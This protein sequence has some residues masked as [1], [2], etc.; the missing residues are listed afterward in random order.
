[1]SDPLSKQAYATSQ[2]PVI[3]PKF[4]LLVGFIVGISVMSIEMAASRLLTPYF[5]N[6][7]YIWTNIIGVIM[8]ALTIGYAWGGKIA[9][10][11][12][13]ERLLYVIILIAGGYFTLVPWLARTTIS[14]MLSLVTENPLS[15]FY[16]SFLSILPLFVVPFVCLGMVSPYIIR[17][18]SHQ[19]TSIGHIAGRIAAY[20]TFGSI[21]GT[22]I[23]VFL[24]IPFLGTQKTIW[25]FAWLL[26]ATALLGLGRIAWSGQSKPKEEKQTF[27]K[28]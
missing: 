10:K 23:P 15:M 11:Y 4:L 1:M 22:F 17:L 7:L 28:I 19:V 21:I 6:S 25:L 27:A 26:I 20:S 8:L 5:G 13:S 16:I 9:D 18:S 2:S 14:L 12:A 24:T 3:Q